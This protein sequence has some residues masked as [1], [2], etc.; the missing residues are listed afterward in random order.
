MEVSGT[1]P[2]GFRRGGAAR[3]GAAL[4]SQSPPQW[5]RARFLAFAPVRDGTLRSPLPR[6]HQLCLNLLGS[7]F[8]S[9]WEENGVGGGRTG[10]PGFV[11]EAPPP[12]PACSSPPPQMM[13]VPEL[14]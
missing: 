11:R 4:V 7:V 10:V 6:L 9:C 1:Q 5:P 12:P 14:P 3:P 2:A 13:Q 8:I